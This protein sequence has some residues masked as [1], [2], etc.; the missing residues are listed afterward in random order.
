MTEKEFINLNINTFIYIEGIN[1]YRKYKILSKNYG[2]KEIYYKVKE[3]ADKQ[4]ITLKKED[5]WKWSK[6]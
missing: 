6:L 4:I 5:C 3:L 1:G 2:E